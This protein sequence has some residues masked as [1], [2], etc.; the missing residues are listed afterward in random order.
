[1]IQ[2]INTLKAADPKKHS[3]VFKPA[4]EDEH[5]I[6]SSIYILNEV[7]PVGANECKITISWPEGGADVDYNALS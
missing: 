4:G 6:C 7:I 1:M 3:I 2:Y 5:V